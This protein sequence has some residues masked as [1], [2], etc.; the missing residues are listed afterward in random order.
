VRVHVDKHLVHSFGQ[1]VRD[2]NA[3]LL[4]LSGALMVEHCTEHIRI[5]HQ[6]VFVHIE[7]LSIVGYNYNVQILN[8]ASSQLCSS[9]INDMVSNYPIFAQKSHH[10]IN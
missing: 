5:D 7:F 6:H 1:W 3:R 2:Y 10:V 8:I 9:I 4:R